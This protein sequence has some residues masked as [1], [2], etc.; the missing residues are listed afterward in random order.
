MAATCSQGGYNLAVPVTRCDACDHSALTYYSR[1]R[2]S[3]NSAAAR[4]TPTN[5]GDGLT[6]MD[7]DGL[8]RSLK[9]LLAELAML[10]GVAGHEQ[11]VVA[12]LVEL[13]SPLV[14]DVEVDSYGNIFARKRG[15]AGAPRL[16]IS[17][18]SDEIGAI[19]KSIEPS[20]MIRFE[21]VGGLVETLTVGRHVRIRGHRG[22]VGVKAGHIQTP[23]ER[24]R[25]PSFRDLY[26][27]LG[28]DSDEDVRR[29]GIRPGDA[30]AYDEPMEE[31]ANPDRVSGKALDNRIACALL[32]DLARR[33]SGVE[34]SC[35]LHL[36]V[37]VQ[38]EVGLRGAQIATYRVNPTAA[39][40]VDT[41]PCGGTPDVDYYRDLSM[42]IGA[43]PVIALASGGSARG[44][45]ANP[46]IRDF[47]LRTAEAAGIP[48]Q[49][50]VFYGGTSDVSAVHLVREG[51][52]AGVVNIPR[53]YSHSPVEMLDINDAVDSLLLVEAA[54]RAFGPDVDLSFLGSE[55]G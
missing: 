34:L 45:L 38:E 49:P 47:L 21:R 39:I 22:V 3:G 36:V 7:R 29:L 37:T 20:G 32:V 53:R 51:I 19:V 46:A 33:L 16:M 9:S 17:A 42:K 25:V 12:R 50:A 1:W 6:P 41:V 40:V 18:H 35:E 28:F 23:E 26:I 48:V 5:G 10:D 31:L 54:A 55:W 27:D 13:L 30:I 2:V 52:P 14:D 43:G 44:H 4:G 11:P 15:P 8:K 24:G